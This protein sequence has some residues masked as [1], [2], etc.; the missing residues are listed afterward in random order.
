LLDFWGLGASWFVTSELGS[1]ILIRLVKIA[2]TVGVALTIMDLSKFIAK[3]MIKPRTDANGN[4][5][6]TGKKQKTLVPL[7]YWII[8]VG[9]SFIGAVIVLGQLGV[10]VTPILAG[11]GIVGLAVGFGAQSLVKDF[12]NG[13]LI[14][15]ESSVAV[16]DV[17]IINGTGGLVEEVTLRTIKMRDLAGNVHVIPNGNVGMITNMTKEFSRYVFDVGVVVISWNRWKFSAWISSAIRQ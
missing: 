5:I 13:L 8:M 14:L 3:Q 1:T 2:I 12:I 11:A 9:T 7:I 16:G 6:A 15:F 10:N 17:I 4:I